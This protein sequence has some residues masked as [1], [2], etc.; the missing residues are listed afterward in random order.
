MR[1]AT[2]AV[3]VAFEV[4]VGVVAG[5]EEQ[6]G[7]R[8]ATKTEPVAELVVGLEIGT[9][10]ELETDPET[11]TGVLQRLMLSLLLLISAEL[12]HLVLSEKSLMMFLLSIRFSLLALVRV[13]RLV[14]SSSL[15]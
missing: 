10:V 15:L 3:D 7:G 6:C 5:A 11:D 13:F 2:A 9:E 8:G 4:A 1:P 12:L 14:P